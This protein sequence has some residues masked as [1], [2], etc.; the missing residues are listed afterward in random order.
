MK[1]YSYTSPYGG[2]YKLMLK[3]VEYAQNGNFGVKADYFDEE[4]GAW[5][6]FVT[7]TVNLGEKLPDGFAYVDTNN[8][9][10]GLEFLLENGI[11]ESDGEVGFS[12]YCCYPLVRFNESAF[13]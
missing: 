1:Q 11:A 2:T 13:K 8:F 3:K 6:P 4:F 7:V 10:G 5:L 9:E 12:G